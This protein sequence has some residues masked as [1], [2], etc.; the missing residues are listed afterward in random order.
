MADFI[1]GEIVA[2]DMITA[3]ILKGGKVNWNLETGVLYIGDT[4]G[5]AN[6]VWDGT[7]LLIS[8]G[9]VKLDIDGIEIGNPTTTTIA[10]H[11]ASGTYY[12]D[13][14]TGNPF[15]SYESGKADID[16]LNVEKVYS[17][18]VLNKLSQD[19]EVFVDSMNFEIVVVEESS[20][21]VL[22]A[23]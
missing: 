10:K 2:A 13:R 11:K 1:T 9:A 21:H 8:Q 12:V 14:N 7:S 23:R 5:T 16:R 6:L 17:P 19:I 3:G 18:H 20:A 22:R 4:L 15:A